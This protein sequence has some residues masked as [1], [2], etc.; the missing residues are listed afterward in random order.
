MAPA[1]KIPLEDIFADIKSKTA[2]FD[3]SNYHGFLAVEVNLSDIKK[4]FYVEVKDGNLSIEP[5]EYNDRQA[6][7]TISSSNF[8]KLINGKLNGT[9]AFLTGKLKIDG[10]IEKVKE[11]ATLLGGE[12]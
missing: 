7:M 1:A 11:L 8:V 9:T 6:K 4:V 5:Y 2:G 12:V 3:G 10:N